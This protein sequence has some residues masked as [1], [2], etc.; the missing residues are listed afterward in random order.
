MNVKVKQ[1]MHR[2]LRGFG[3]LI[4][5]MRSHLPKQSTGEGSGRSDSPPV[6]EVAVGETMST[7]ALLPS[8][9]V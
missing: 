3:H 5:E 9:Q 1:A 7:S 4:E 2:E 6:S 8:V